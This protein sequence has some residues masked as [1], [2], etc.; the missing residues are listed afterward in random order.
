V[1]EVTFC[2]E[3]FELPEKAS[4]L[5][6]MEYASVAVGGV[7]SG[8]LIGLAALY[9]LLAECIGGVEAEDG[10]RERQAEWDRFRALARRHR[11]D[12]EALFEVVKAVF[13]AYAERPT[14]RPSSSSDGPTT[15]EATSA[16]V[17]SLP[18][19]E[20]YEAEGRPAWALQVVQAQEARQAM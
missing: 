20:R 18:V 9:D 12:D 16:G 2:E 8:S 15:T 1:A 6:L 10:T 13:S 19:K 11:V 14:S 4:T 17:S 3:T 7:D 5:A